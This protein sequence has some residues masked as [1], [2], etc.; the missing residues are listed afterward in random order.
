MKIMRVYS[1]N[2]WSERRVD[3]RA[4][5]LQRRFLLLLSLYFLLKTFRC[6]L[7]MYSEHW[8]FQ[9]TGNNCRF[10]Y[11]KV[12]EISCVVQAYWMESGATVDSV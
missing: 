6:R 8:E 3:R 12:T 5:T 10:T 4:G 9:K 2:I 1:H 11:L 7:R